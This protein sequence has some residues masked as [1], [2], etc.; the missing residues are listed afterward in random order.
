MGQ[1]IGVST[2]RIKN[3]DADPA[4]WLTIYQNYQGRR[5]SRLTEIDRDNVGDLVLAFSVGLPGIAEGAQLQGTPL[6]DSGFMYVTNA[7]G[8][9]IKI[10]VHDGQRGKI[11]W[12]MDPGVNTAVSAVHAKTRRPAQR[13]PR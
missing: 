10:D 3:A 1:E 2:T 6:V 11:L 9:V 8:A 7:W 5:Y 4:N 13:T 12:I